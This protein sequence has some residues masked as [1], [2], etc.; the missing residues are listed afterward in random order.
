MASFH[1]AVKSGGGGRGATHAAYIERE[2]KYK[3]ADKDDLEHVQTLNLPEWAANSAEF[4]R[5]SD[6]RERANSNGYREYEIALP[7]EMTPAQRLAFVH[8]FIATEIGDKN[9]CTFAIHCPLAALEG[10]EQPHAHIMFSERTHDSIERKTPEHYFKRANSKEPE[11]GGCKKSNGVPK[12][13][14]ERKAEL[15]AF[16]ARFADLQNKH[17]EKNGCTDRVTHLSLKARGLE[18]PQEGHHGPRAVKVIQAINAAI[19]P[20]E[21]EINRDAAELKIITEQ[22]IRNDRIRDEAFAKIDGNLSDARAAWR[23]T[24][25]AVK[26]SASDLEAG[27]G[28]AADHGRNLGRAIEGTERR[29]TERYLGQAV[30]AVIGKLD[31][32]NKIIQ[33]T[34]EH[35]GGAYDSFRGAIKQITV[36]LDRRRVAREQ[37]RPVD[38][39]HNKTTLQV[40]QDYAENNIANPAAREVFLE[41]GRAIEAAKLI[42]S[43]PAQEHQPKLTDQEARSAAVQMAVQ[44]KALWDAAVLAERAVYLKEMTEQ[45]LNK[46]NAHVVEHREHLD[47]K[48]LLF[49]RDHWE[50]KR[51]R[52]KNRDQSNRLVWENLKDGKYPFIAR[53]REDVQKAVERRVSDQNPELAQSMP[54]ALA[55]LQAEQQRLSAEQHKQWLAQHQQREREAREARDNG[56]EKDSPSPGM[57]R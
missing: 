19:R 36:T 52:F 27:D 28:L 7:R 33:R 3:T 49:G 1:C 50:M 13:P 38:T 2:G 8:E 6:R 17:L 15:V 35:V 55:A 34:V 40:L 11:R 51:E 23:G 43:P 57:S 32:A 25:S 20:L 53:D 9:V 41:K 56:H 16:R 44:L 37:A 29:I 39:R 47:N 30:R 4:W 18:G 31:V 12:T 48:P 24:V 46:A 21:K 42:A 5:E 45:A 10:G 14:T 54:R 26:A 22:E